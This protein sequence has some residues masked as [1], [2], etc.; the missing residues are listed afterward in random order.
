MNFS[1]LNRSKFIEQ[2]SSNN[3]DLLVIGGGITGC[4]IALDAALRGMKVALIEKNDF[5]SGTSSRSTKLIHGGLRYLKQMEF[6]LVRDVGTERAV[7]HRNARHIVIPEKMLLPIVKHGSL[8]KPSSS[9]GLLVYDLLAGVKKDERRKMLDKHDTQ[10]AEP[11]LAFDNLVGG[12]LYF[13]YR[14]DDSRLVI[15]NA[16]SAFASDALLLNYAESKN[17]VYDTAG[18]ITGVRVLDKITDTYFEI[19]AGAVVNACGPWVDLLRKEDNSLKGKRLQLTKGVHIVFPY[20]KLPLKQAAYF[21]VGDGRMIFAVPRNNI[22]YVGTTD[23]I[24]N[25]NLDAPQCSKEDAEYLVAAVNKMFSGVKLK[26]DDIESSWA[27]LRPLI[28]EEGKSA[29]ELSRKDEIMISSSGLISI[30]GGKLTGY[31][32]MAEKI[33]DLAAK[34]LGKDFK[35]CKTKGYR[36]SGGEFENEE[37]FND[38]FAEL[39]KKGEAEGISSE[40]IKEWFFRYGTNALKVMEEFVSLRSRNSEVEKMYEAAELK[41]CLEH[42]MVFYLSDYFIR[43]TGKIFFDRENSEKQIQHLNDLLSKQLQLDESSSQK[44]LLAAKEEFQ[45]AVTFQ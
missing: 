21:D 34:R 4:G 22:T 29:S 41:Y 30:A 20:E 8:G 15:E 6:K 38:S 18:K 43:R 25:Q 33:V 26:L 36:L 7:V 9:L 14:T 3:F 27:G 19:K 37:K 28:F 1:N 10:K 13:E 40:K 39:L 32:L 23:T 31:R 16:K 12:G 45:S 2:L 35:K 44:M 5:A 11:L 24:Y 42:E 17:F